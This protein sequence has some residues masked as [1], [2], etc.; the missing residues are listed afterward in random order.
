MCIAK[1]YVALRWFI[2]GAGHWSSPW[3]R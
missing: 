2:S 3:G 1:I